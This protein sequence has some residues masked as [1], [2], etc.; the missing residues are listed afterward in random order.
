MPKPLCVFTG[1]PC[2]GKCGYKARY[3]PYPMK[4]PTPIINRVVAKAALAHGPRSNR[5]PMAR[6]LNWKRPVPRLTPNIRVM[7]F[8]AH[9]IGR[10][11]ALRLCV[12]SFG[13]M[14]RIACT[15]GWC[16][17]ALRLRRH[18]KPNGFIPNRL[19]FNSLEVQSTYSRYFRAFWRRPAGFYPHKPGR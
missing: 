4:R 8:R 13:K 11:V 17:N 19:V 2:T 15:T 3:Q 14:A 16:L 7:I 1:K 12:L 9:R 18:G 10:G 5:G 6:A